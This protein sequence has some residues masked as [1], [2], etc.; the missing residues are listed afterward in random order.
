MAEEQEAWMP[1]FALEPGL[2]K[3]I[4]F[5][6]NLTRRIVAK[7]DM[8]EALAGAILKFGNRMDEETELKLQALYQLCL[9]CEMPIEHRWQ[10]F[11]FITEA[12]QHTEVIGIGVYVPFIL[13]E[14][15][16]GIVC[17][18]AIDYTSL[19]PLIDDDPMSRP[20]EIIRFIESTEPK[21]VGAL[22]GGLLCLGDPRVCHLLH[23]LRHTLSSEEV[24]EVAGCTTGFISASTFEFIV[25]WLE[26]LEGDDQD[27]VFGSL[28]SNLALQRRHAAIPSVATGFRPFPVDSVTSDERRA[29][30]KWVPLED[31][32]RR[33]AP[34]LL[35]LERSEPEPKAMSVVISEWGIA[36]RSVSLSDFL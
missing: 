26:S 17:T 10:V 24:R 16:R 31:Y 21:N 8:R 1:R 13:E 33:I 9:I 25:D 7:A 5:D 32:T 22:F 27:V 18:A 6:E 30:I 19:G 35:A 3:E 23:P 12:V 2:F 36:E 34:R 11:A 20:K 4:A 29:M 15:D 14:P 28:A